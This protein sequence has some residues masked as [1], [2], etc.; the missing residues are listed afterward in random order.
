MIT[1][2]QD[3]NVTV[4]IFLRYYIPSLTKTSYI[5]TFKEISF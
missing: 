1:P 5:V 2:T 3:V 4:A